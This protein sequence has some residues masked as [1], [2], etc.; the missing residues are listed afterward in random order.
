MRTGQTDRQ[1][2]MTK[3]LVAFR[4]SA[5]E[6][7]NRDLIA[8]FSQFVIVVPIRILSISEIRC[9]TRRYSAPSTLPFAI[10]TDLR[11]WL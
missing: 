8:I 9:A 1:T 2:D 6:P 7:K 4:N 10:I 3:L 5:N 11:A